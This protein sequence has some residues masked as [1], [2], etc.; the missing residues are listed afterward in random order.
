MNISQKLRISCATLNRIVFPND[1]LLVALNK[2][3]LEQEKKVY[4]PIGGATE[5]YQVGLI[6]SIEVELERPCDLRL[7]IQEIDLKRFESWFRSK[8]GRETDSFRELRE[9]LVD[10]KNKEE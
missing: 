5:L 6:D 10:S 4:S 7:F 2:N 8:H 3:R 1:R 9:E